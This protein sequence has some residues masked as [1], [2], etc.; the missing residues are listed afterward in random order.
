MSER[1]T[2]SGLQD[3]PAR[4]AWGA[5]KCEEIRRLA[6]FCGLTIQRVRGAWRYRSVT[7]D[8]SALLAR[9]KEIAATRVHCGYRRVNVML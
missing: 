3:I 5:A 1:R 6:H 7:R 9:I 2:G 8:A 4:H